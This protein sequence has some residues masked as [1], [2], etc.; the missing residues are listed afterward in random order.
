MIRTSHPL[1]S[2][3]GVYNAIYVVGDSV[4]ETMF[5]GEGAGSL[6]AAS[7]VVGDL[8]EVARRIQSGSAPT[9]GCTC[10][11]V[12]PLRDIADL[13]TGY[14]IRLEVAD[15]PGV[16]AAVASVF[17]AHEVSIASVIQKRAEE[18]VAEIV[19]VTHCAREASVRSALSEIEALDVVS[20]TAAV[21][22]VEDI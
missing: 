9:V 3:N 16:L 15:K 13:E 5:F 8:I 6:P 14:Y 7:A 2:V 21:I 11:E 4:G 10:T 18:G 17:G 12:L 1:A 22:R 19:Y 20:R